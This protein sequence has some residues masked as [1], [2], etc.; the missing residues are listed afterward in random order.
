MVCVQPLFSV[1]HFLFQRLLPLS[2]SLVVVRGAGRR[3]LVAFSSTGAR[4]WL[5]LFSLHSLT[6]P[7]RLCALRARCAALPATRRAPRSTCWLACTASTPSWCASPRAAQAAVARARGSP[8]CFPPRRRSLPSPRR[9]QS[10]WSWCV[11]VGRRAGAR[12]RAWPLAGPG[13]CVRL[14][15]PTSLTP[16]PR[17]PPSPFAPLQATTP[18]PEAAKRQV[19]PKRFF[20]PALEGRRVGALFEQA[21]GL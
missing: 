16:L 4:C 10:R 2:K 5:T 19:V 1:D 6:Q 3:V 17:R 20:S 8:A 13:K 18:V 14:F 7:A 12:R 9:R 15:W 11:P 21:G